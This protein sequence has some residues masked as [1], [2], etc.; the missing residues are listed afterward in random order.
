MSSNLSGLTLAKVSFILKILTVGGVLPD[1]V[2]FGL[3]THADITRGV[4][5]MGT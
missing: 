2:S 3:G 4:D 1:D 5:R